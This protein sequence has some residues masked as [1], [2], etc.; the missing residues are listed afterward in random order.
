MKT[1]RW[2]LV[3][4]VAIMSIVGSLMIPLLI[5]V[6]ASVGATD[7]LAEHS[8][9]GLTLM[10]VYFGMAF[11]GRIRYLKLEGKPIGRR[12]DLF[13]S[14]FHRGGGA[15][16]VLLAWWNCYTGLVRIG[17]EDSHFAV[18]VLS[19]FPMGYDLPIFGQIRRFCFWP[20]ISFIF[21]IFLIAEIRMRRYDKKHRKNLE[22]VI[23]GK[24]SVWE[25]CDTE[26]LERMT[27]E[28]FLDMTRLGSQFCVVQ[29]RVLDITNF[30][31]IH[32]GGRD[33]LRYACGS[34]IT[35]E[36]FGKRDVDGIKHTHSPGALRLLR[37][38]VRAVLV[39]DN[40]DETQPD[41]EEEGGGGGGVAMPPSLSRSTT[42]QIFRPGKVISV[43]YLT[44]NIELNEKSKP[45]IL[46]RL[47][48]PASSR[49][50]H[51]RKILP[52]CAFTFRG[53]DS[54]GKRQP[55]LPT[56]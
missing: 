15:I 30:M 2:R 49:L 6:E 14:I 31:D 26:G 36:L 5:G 25:D 43:K 29:G 4:H 7:K 9:V 27:M 13:S 51:K 45:V 44:P 54:K 56:W 52:S 34:D 37:T 38:L 35:R 55:P 28:T 19:S 8:L 50:F 22:D 3:A 21:L 17:P 42:T 32:P 12:T 39:V 23:S 24:D 46:L 48:L 1:R 33:M 16:I 40:K 20:Y 11:A 53:Q 18:V 47:S 41:D 10:L